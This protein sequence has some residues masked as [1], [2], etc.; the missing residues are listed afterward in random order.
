VVAFV[1][2]FAATKIVSGTVAAL[3]AE[4]LMLRTSDGN[5][6]A[7]IDPKCRFWRARRPATL[8]EFEIGA[9]VTVRLRVTETETAA[10][11]ITDEVSWAWLEKL[12]KTPVEGWIQKLEPKQLHVRLA[13][14]STATYR[15]SA[16]SRVTLG[17]KAAAVQD[18]QPDMRVIL[19]GRTLP[20]LD[21]WLVEA[22]DQPLIRA[23]AKPKSKSK[24][25][26]GPEKKPPVKLGASGTL[27]GVVKR[28]LLGMGMIDVTVEPFDYH[29]TYGKQTK[30]TLDGAA[31]TADDA[32]VGQKCRITYKRDTFGRILAQKVELISEKKPSS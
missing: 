8:A 23:P 3:S 9:S 19:R 22:S 4:E 28:P 25:A 13:D 15:T 10:R 20:T 21:L 32:K 18:L 16:K 17:G 30:F 5:V 14:G 1:Q 12:R 29:I 2:G 27:T 6:P 26:S 31:A 11:E 7:K 24:G